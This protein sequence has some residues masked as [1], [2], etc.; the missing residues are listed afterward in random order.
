[1]VAMRDGVRLATDVYRPALPDGGPAPGRFPVI[2]TRT[3]YDKSNPVMQ[4][5]PVAKF[6][7]PRG[8][9][10]VVQDLRGRG[11]SE[12]TGQY[13]HTANE[14]EGLDGFDTL[15][16]IAAQPW[17]NGRVG[18]VGSS[19]SG[20]VQNVA[21]LHRPPALKALWVDVAPT[22]AIDWEARQG[23]AMALQMFTALFLHAYDAQ[24]IRNDP[25]AQRRIEDAA[26]NMRDVICRQPFR[27][28]QT[29]LA[30]VPNLESVLFHYQN[31]GV[32]NAWWGMEAMEQKT[33]W[34]RFADIPAVLST[35]WFDPF[36]EEVVAQFVA[37]SRQNKSPQRLVVGPWNHV[38]MRGGATHTGDLD[39]GA[40][41]AWG[42]AAYNAERLRWFDRWLK[43][44]D[45]G[46]DADPPVR[47][48]MLGGGSGR[49]IGQG[50]L[51]HGGTWRRERQW[52]PPRSTPTPFYLRAGGLLAPNEAEP[53]TQTVP[54]T[55][56]PEHP[57]PTLGGN[58]VA[59]YEWIDPPPGMDPAYVPQRA[60]MHSIV[61]EGP[62][63]QR[64]QPG[65]VG[66]R[67]PF[68][69]LSERK[70]VLVFQTPPLTREVEIAGD[71]EAVLYVSSSAVDTDVTV[72]L[73]DVYPPSPDY[74]EG[75]HLNL[76]DSILRGR[77]RE[78]FDA[79]RPMRPGTVYRFVVRLPPLAN[80]FKAGHRIRLDIA[81]SNF[82]RFDV[83]PNT[84]EPLGRHTHAV[85]AH[86]AVHFGPERPSAI[87]L[88][89]VG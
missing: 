65:M 2:L 82:P 73:L 19:H 35:G 24:E 39:F 33:R 41:G 87:L 80:L 26:R 83:N 47:F 16:W 88:P 12:G 30:A 18:M 74:P 15:A 59:M 5:G 23:G 72:K 60:R 34:S 89:V 75:Y 61:P 63:H 84:G 67:P 76:A 42:I 25:A 62:M 20:I 78:G 79:E 29:A 44:L 1:M 37:L 81:S 38:G 22:S 56:D 58:V 10:A 8:Y 40:A 66:C 21:A 69:L 64:E 9:V 85:P 13:F 46:V 4:V 52:P 50:R 43:D 55:H 77:F 3:S 32:H 48:F 54:W 6:F 49:K 51:D 70:D 28:G 17:C 14:R 68:G 31:E 53:A 11:E 7:A 45:T 36:T 27:P 86:N 57:V 71:M